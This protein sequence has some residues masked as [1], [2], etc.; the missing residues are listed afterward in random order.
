MAGGKILVGVLWA[1]LVL[2]GVILL[3][4]CAVA[5]EVDVTLR[6]EIYDLE[7]SDSV[8]E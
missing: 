5:L 7:K 1:V 4:G 2:G 8:Y 6:Y 3:T